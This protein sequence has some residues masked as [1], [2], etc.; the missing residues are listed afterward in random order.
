MPLYHRDRRLYCVTLEFKHAPVRVAA[1][2][3]LPHRHQNRRFAWLGRK[4]G[5]ISKTCRSIALRN[6]RGLIGARR[7]ELYAINRRR[8][9]GCFTL[10]QRTEPTSHPLSHLRE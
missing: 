2:S 3:E 6:S 7:R 5:D 4:Y 8:W 10:V 1:F 9:N